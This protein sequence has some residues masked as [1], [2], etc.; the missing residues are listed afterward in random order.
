MPSRLV[1]VWT[2]L[3]EELEVHLKATAKRRHLTRDQALRQAVEEYV[4][5][6][7]DSPLEQ[8]V[9]ES[10]GPEPLLRV[11][12]GIASMALVREGS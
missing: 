11:S 7:G 12:R 8:S 10:G 1:R 6:Q 9:A 4:R 5:H 2:D 3:P